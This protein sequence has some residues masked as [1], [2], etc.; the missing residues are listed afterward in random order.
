MT[1][2]YVYRILGG[3]VSL[4][5]IEYGLSKTDDKDI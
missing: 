4:E 3:S 1:P 2:E 5:E